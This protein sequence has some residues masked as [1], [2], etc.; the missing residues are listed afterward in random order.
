MGWV[1]LE[2]TVFIFDEARLSKWDRDLWH[3]FFKS[4]HSFPKRRAIAFTSYGSP[5]SHITIA[6]TPVFIA[7]EQRV[8]LRPIH[9]DDD[10]ASVGLLFTRTEFG[11]LVTKQY[12]K[13]GL[14]SS[15]LDNV[16]DLT[17]G[18]VGAFLDF[19]KIIV[20]HKVSTF[21]LIV[22]ICRDISVIPQ[23]HSPTLHLE[24]IFERSQSAGIG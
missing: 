11:D 10:T 2:Q 8:S 17:A 5:G 4:M 7:D 12:P 9:Y 1:Q 3:N 13:N 21:A 20:N 23:R 24:F 18:H 15:F 6:G 19:I 22:M 16:F 14:D